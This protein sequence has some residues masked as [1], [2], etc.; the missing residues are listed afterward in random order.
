L[1]L[2]DDADDDDDNEVGDN[3][4]DV[5]SLSQPLRAAVATTAADGNRPLC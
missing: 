1:Y 3:N 4:D 2:D 5:T